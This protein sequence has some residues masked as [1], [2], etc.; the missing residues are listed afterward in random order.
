MTTHAWFPAR[1]LSVVVWKWGDLYSADHVNRFAAMVRRN[2]SIP[3]E[4][5]CITDDGAGLSAPVIV[6]PMPLKH[7]G[8]YRALRRVEVLARHMEL[9][10]G[11]RIL[12]LD[13]DLVVLGD[14]TTLCAGWTGEV[15]AAMY[16]HPGASYNPSFL[17]VRAGALDACWR[18]FNADPSG[19]F[20]AAIRSGWSRGC[21]DQ[22]VIN[23]Y[24]CGPASEK[25]GRPDLAELVVALPEGPA[26][27]LRAYKRMR[28]E[29]RARPPEG[30]RIVFFTGRQAQVALASRQH[31]WIREALD[32]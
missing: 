26:T 2:L 27:G 14:V 15:A 16:W 28:P 29:D 18:A 30:T 23:H 32:G 9:V 7:A 12:Q 24:L 8:T 19:T 22:A 21:S 4:F 6:H 10:L 17:Y 11:P 5:H 25:V 31:E 1:K 13:L 3:H 20:E